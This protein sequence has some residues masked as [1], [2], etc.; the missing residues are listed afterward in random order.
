MNKIFANA[1]T[2]VLVCCALV[3][4]GLAIRRELAV[5]SVPPAAYNPEVRQV[6]DWRR[7]V[8]GSRIG[9]AHARVTITEFSDF[10]CP[11]CGAM[12]RRLRALRSA[13]PGEIAL[14][15]RHFPLQYHPFAQQAAHASICAERQGRFEAYHDAVFAQQDSLHGEVWPVL[16][17]AAHIPDMR[18]FRACMEEK[19]P[20][21]RIERDLA[22]GRRL[23]VHSTPSILVNG[24]LVTGNDLGA[25]EIGRAHV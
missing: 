4:T 12:A 2:A 21:Q 15:Y 23:G 20:A 10:Q 22:A 11:Y 14:V 3:V 13:N 6:G 17:E 7:Y 19:E 1:A 24:T 25:I 18:L 16:A 8:E 5:S 9:P